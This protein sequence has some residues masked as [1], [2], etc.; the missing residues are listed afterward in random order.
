MPYTNTANE[1]DFLGE[2]TVTG[3]FAPQQ[4]P[5][6]I[7]E[8]QRQEAIARSAQLQREAQELSVAN[9]PYQAERA[10]AQGG[11]MY[12]G[13][14]AEAKKASDLAAGITGREYRTPAQQKAWEKTHQRGFA[15]NLIRDPITMGIL[16]APYA[17][18]GG[19]MLLGGGAAG[20]AA[21][22]GPGITTPI[23]AAPTLGAVGTMASPFAAAT[24]PTLGAVGTVASPFAAGAVPAVAGSTLPAMAGPGGGGLSLGEGLSLGKLGLDAAGIVASQIRT[25]AEKDLIKKQEEL[26]AAAKARQ[27]Q[28]QQ[29]GMNRLGQQM[30]AFAPQNRMMAEMF[31]PEAAF[32]GQQMGAMADDPGAKPMSA[33]NVPPGTPLNREDIDRSKADQARQQQVAGAFGPPPQGPAPLQQRAPQPAR[34]F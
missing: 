13:E 10:K 24:P 33:Y 17:V 22:A 8:A 27:I 32:T 29:E 21:G 4:T 2:G 23:T 16:A 34:R 1:A 5:A 26:A 3:A 28:V 14:D 12:I 30:L 20:V 25:K 31:G 18:A 11:T 19:G 6:Q 7:A 9:Q 15:G